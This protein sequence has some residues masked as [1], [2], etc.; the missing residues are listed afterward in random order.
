MMA[1]TTGIDLTPPTAN[2]YQSFVFSP[3]PIP[4]WMIAAFDRGAILRVN[5]GGSKFLIS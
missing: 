2:P 4:F 5:G 3:S 1:N